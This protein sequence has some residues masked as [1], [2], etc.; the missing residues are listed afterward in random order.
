MSGDIISAIRFAV[1]MPISNASRQKAHVYWRDDEPPL[2]E[3][4]NWLKNFGQWG[5]P[6]SSMV[7]GCTERVSILAHQYAGRQVL[8][9][10]TSRGRLAAILAAQGCIVTTVDQADRGASTNLM[11]MGVQTSFRM[12][13]ISCAG[14]TINS[15]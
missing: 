8:D 10:G 2:I 15:L 4:F 13:L 3:R 7:P 5:I 6:G 14:W 1:R 11:Q 9:I 12:L